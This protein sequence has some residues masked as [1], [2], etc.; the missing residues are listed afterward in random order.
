MDD[1][2]PDLVRTESGKLVG[3]GSKVEW[4]EDR[5]DDQVR[6]LGCICGMPDTGWVNREENSL[7]PQLETVYFHD[8]DEPYNV[9]DKIALSSFEGTR[10]VII[11]EIIIFDPNSRW[12]KYKYK[13]QEFEKY[14][15]RR[16]FT[17]QLEEVE[18][19]HG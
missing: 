10:I 13:F 5:W 12:N 9:G 4:T 2:L 8:K 14:P 3:E 1:E 11:T 16:Y 18:E 19:K 6:V 15:F 7:I 17:G